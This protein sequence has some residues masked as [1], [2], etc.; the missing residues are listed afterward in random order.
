MEKREGERERDAENLHWKPNKS[1]MDL[2]YCLVVWMQKNLS[3]AI[4]QM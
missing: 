4:M 1:E 2:V 3:V